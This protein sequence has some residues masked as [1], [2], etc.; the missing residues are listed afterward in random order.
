MYTQNQI[1]DLNT[2]DYCEEMLYHLTELG[3]ATE[4]EISLTTAVAGW[5]AEV[6]NGILYYKAGLNGLGQL[7]EE[8]GMLIEE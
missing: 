8:N 7:L 3:V 2:A 4:E 6:M 1:D 5:N